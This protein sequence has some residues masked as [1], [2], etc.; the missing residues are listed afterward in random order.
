MIDLIELGSQLKATRKQLGLSQTELAAPGKLPY[1]RDRLQ[2]SHQDHA[3]PRPR[4]QSHPT[5]QGTADSGR[6]DRRGCTRS[7]FEFGPIAKARAVSTV[8]ANAARPS[9]DP[10]I[11]PTRAVSV[12]MPVRTASWN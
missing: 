8:T 10:K 1:R 3:R 9:S 7:C 11:E 4:P 6:P 12:T 2:A 5:Q